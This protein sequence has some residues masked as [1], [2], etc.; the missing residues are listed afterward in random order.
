MKGEPRGGTSGA[1]QGAGG[2]RRPSQLFGFPQMAA[3]CVALQ[4]HDQ[5][6]G[7]WHDGTWV[8]RAWGVEEAMAAA[9][10]VEAETPG[11]WD[12]CGGRL[13]VVGGGS[14]ERAC[15]TWI[16]AVESGVLGGEE[17]GKHAV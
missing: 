11:T 7:T 12:L 14:Q 3:P 2:Q 8:P 17:V 5:Q 6:D 4:Q 16:L 1:T 13:S 9:E 15:R 10:E